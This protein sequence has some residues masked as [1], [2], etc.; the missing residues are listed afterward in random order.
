MG[1]R[2]WIG[3]RW[4]GLL[5]LFVL[6]SIGAH[7]YLP[8]TVPEPLLV[9]AATAIVAGIALVHWHAKLRAALQA[10]EKRW[11]AVVPL[12]VL[13]GFLGLRG[14]DRLFWSPIVNW[15]FVV[16]AIAS[17]VAAVVYASTRVELAQLAKTHVIFLIGVG[18]TLTIAGI[19]VEA[20]MPWTTSTNAAALVTAIWL[21][22]AGLLYWRSVV[23]WAVIKE[24][25]MSLVIAAAVLA[26]LASHA[27]EQLPWRPSI[28]WRF[29]ILPGA[30]V[31]ALAIIGLVHLQEEDRKR[32]GGFF[33]GGLYTVVVVGFLLGLVVPHARLFL[34]HFIP[35]PPPL[36]E[37]GIR[38][39][40]REPM[41][42]RSAAQQVT[43]VADNQT[44]HLYGR[45][46]P[47]QSTSVDKLAGASI[48]PP[49]LNLFAK[50]LLQWSLRHILEDRGDYP[51]VHLGD[52]LDISC[53]QEFHDFAHTMT[54]VVGSK[55]WALAPGNHDGFYFGNFDDVGIVPG[56]RQACDGLAPG[57][58]QGAGQ[59]GPMNKLE[60]IRAY[61]KLLRDTHDPR[62]HVCLANDQRVEKPCDNFYRRIYWTEESEMRRSFILQ[63]LDISLR[64]REPTSLLLLDTAAYDA[65]VSVPSGGRVLSV[66][67]R[68]G[69]ILHEQFITARRWVRSSPE[70]RFLLAGHHNA[71][72]LPD[73]AGERLE[74]LLAEPNVHSVYVSAHSHHGHYAAHAGPN[75]RGEWLEVNVGSLLDWPQE[76]VE[77]QLGRAAGPVVVRSVRERLENL[78]KPGGAYYS[79]QPPNCR[80]S[81][82]Y[83]RAYISLSSTSK[84]SKQS[85]LLIAKNLARTYQRFA[86]DHPALSSET[87]EAIRKTTKEILARSKRATNRSVARIQALLRSLP[88]ATQLIAEV[89]A[90]R[91]DVLC[92]AYRA[93]RYDH[94]RSIPGQSTAP[95]IQLP[96][97]PKT[98]ENEKP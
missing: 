63:E 38:V 49:V 35:P 34:S 2:A 24:R 31:S 45:P 39:L 55:L 69:E 62:K 54:E 40:A 52:S 28:N 86:K 82:D 94:A 60:F 97:A 30:I 59:T 26:L 32:W 83:G 1:A 36:P 92:Q 13:L 9:V 72:Q 18:V 85:Y 8:W 12:V 88:T 25:A 56:W 91:D 84:G 95:W 10:A 93:S 57:M 78:W 3:R 87:T 68:R 64:D 61:L 58:T 53:K 48:R 44:H 43:F 67:G 37:H 6:L 14:Q 22:S 42:Y 20:S 79:E 71:E 73:L 65:S 90:A 19:W 29:I 7:P 98:E 21:S 81:K 16:A 50:P 77:L 15:L 47:I 89:P 66:A 23:R 51:I 75:K 17:L 80:K 11:Y 27:H 76:W 33:R 96:W 46:F 70:R 74:L 41:E 4:K 5:V